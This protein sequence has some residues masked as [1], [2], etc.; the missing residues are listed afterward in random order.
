M[1]YTVRCPVCLKD[2]VVAG[3]P[4]K[5]IEEHF[6]CSACQEVMDADF[7]MAADRD[8]VRKWVELLDRSGLYWVR[9]LILH[10]LGRSKDPGFTGLGI[11]SESEPMP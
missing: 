3:P 5:G 1:V 2:I 4:P 9:T 7:H 11:E 8:E 6:M 10:L